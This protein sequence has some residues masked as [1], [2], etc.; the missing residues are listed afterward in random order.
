AEI[1]VQIASRETGISP[2]LENA[3]ATS[4]KDIVVA[5]N[6]LGTESATAAEIQTAVS[7]LQASSQALGLILLEKDEDGIITFALDT[8]TTATVTKVGEGYGIL[9]DTLSTASPSMD[10]ANGAAISNPTNN[11]S[12]T[13]SSDAERFTFNY[14]KFNWFGDQLT[15]TTVRDNYYFRYSLDYDTTTTTTYI[16]LVNK[17]T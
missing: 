2:E 5:K 13:P 1:L 8:A 7:S 9:V 17:T 15:D 3:I 4:I 14:S 12:F 10:E 11:T 6:L 16:E